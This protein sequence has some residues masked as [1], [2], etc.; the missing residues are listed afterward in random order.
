M[1]W[2]ASIS[3]FLLYQRCL[4]T[5]NMDRGMKGQGWELLGPQPPICLHIFPPWDQQMHLPSR[6]A[7]P[8]P[9]SLCLGGSLVQGWHLPVP[10]SGPLSASGVSE[11]QPHTPHWV[12]RAV[13][14]TWG[15]RESN[16]CSGSLQLIALS[17][18]HQAVPA[19]GTAPSLV[20]GR[21]YVSALRGSC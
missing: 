10:G 5:E 19:Y 20:S 9:G 7:G 15:C 11:G 1:G 3:C 6:C 18:R 12:P 21:A 13:T 16:C 17:P 2:V 4:M 14:R 8:Q